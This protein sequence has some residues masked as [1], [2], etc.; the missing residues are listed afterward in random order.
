MHLR[1]NHSK[2]KIMIEELGY[3]EHQVFV[4][5]VADAAT[6]VKE[7]TGVDAVIWVGHKCQERIPF[8]IVEAME[9][10]VL[11]SID[12]E[13]SGS[14]DTTLREWLVLNKDILLDYWNDDLYPTSQMVRQIKRLS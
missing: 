1:C 12:E 6:L 5:W 14:I 2:L 3:N 13:D 10:K 9:G 7:D 8:V 4:E 11:V